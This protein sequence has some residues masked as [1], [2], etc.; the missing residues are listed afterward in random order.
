[1]TAQFLNVGVSIFIIISGYLYAKKEIKEGYFKWIRKRA[2]RI[3]VPMYFFMIFLLIILIANWRIYLK[4]KS[5][6]RARF[7]YDF[8]KF[9]VTKR[10][11]KDNRAIIW[12]HI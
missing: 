7:L 5:K 12:Q 11:S 9:S 10:A 6:R 3:L 2:K 4:D 1:M 8:I